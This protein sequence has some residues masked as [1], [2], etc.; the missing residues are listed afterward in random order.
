MHQEGMRQLHWLSEVDY[1]DE[2]IKDNIFRLFLVEES[3]VRYI[4]MGWEEE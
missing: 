1:S 3:D 2:L 4:K